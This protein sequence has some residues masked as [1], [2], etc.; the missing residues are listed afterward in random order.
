MEVCSAVGQIMFDVDMLVSRLD[1]L[2]QDGYYFCRKEGCRLAITRKQKE[3]ILDGYREL[4][5]KSTALVFT[6]YRGTNVKQINAL[7]AAM[8]ETGAE[9]VVVKNTLL[10]IALEEQGRAH[11]ESLLSGPNGVVFI[12]E[13]V[14]KSVKA[15]KDWIKEAKIGEITGALL[16]N[17]VLDA[18]GAD[19][20]SDLPTKEQILAQI[21]GTIN[22]PAGS[23]VRIINAPLASL[24]RVINA[25][26][27][28]QNEAAA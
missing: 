25:H 2:R 13:D 28:K 10:R 7:R 14:A 19:K 4:V 12:S 26:V 17:S 21:L 9:Y 16:E 1:A 24:V 22:A 3:E 8:K 27:E 11:P 20:L 18:E 15:L 5:K 6:N 23:L